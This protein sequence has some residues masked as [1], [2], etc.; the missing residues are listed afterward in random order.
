MP[1]SDG[2]ASPLRLIVGLG[3]PGRRYQNTP[4]NLG[5]MLI[6]RLAD[7]HG[8]Q[9]KRREAGALVGTGQVAGARVL[10]AKPQTYMNLSGPSVRA[11]L[12][13]ESA[14]AGDTI[15]VYDDLDLPWTACA[16]G[17]GKPVDITES[18]R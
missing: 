5:F 4:H 12:Q 18:N 1:E 9:V 14:R 11:L 6:D 3:N 8:I 15:L 2:A 10:L 7:R 17:E 16:S 13:A